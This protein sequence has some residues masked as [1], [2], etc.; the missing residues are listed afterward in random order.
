MQDI[1]LTGGARIDPAP[2]D[3]KPERWVLKPARLAR[4]DRLCGLALAATDAALL[5]ARA[6]P[7]R[8]NAGRIAVVVGSAFGCH[9]TNEEY[10]R[11]LLAEG[12][13]GASPRLFAYTLPSSPIGEITIHYGARGPA[14][15]LISGRHAG[16][17]ALQRA[18][19]LCAAG[20]ADLAIAVAVDT[21]GA[22]LSA[23]GH[24]VGDC[25]AAIIVEP[26]DAARG[27]GATLWAEIAGS[28]GA[29]RHR[30]PDEA[31]AAARRHALSE[32]GIAA[33]DSAELAQRGGDDAVAPL[34]ALADWLHGPK[35]FTTLSVADDAG[36]AAALLLI[37]PAHL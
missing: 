20:L 8:W 11:G 35:D 36:G 34:A 17:E 28:G 18:A 1:H 31:A 30:D 26:G 9:A 23:L 37:P 5:D 25:A 29:F 22:T 15:A 27:R 13:R 24:V 4:M 3:L 32:R 10:Y 16:V 2:A 19:R 12:P 7:G 21:G 14:E 33:L 6:D